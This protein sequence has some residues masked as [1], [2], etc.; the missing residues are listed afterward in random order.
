MPTLGIELSDAGF[1]TATCAGDEPRLVDIPDREGS[2]EWPGF[3]YHDGTGYTFG[4]AAEEHWFVQPRRV[5]HNFW[6]RLA[7]EPCALSVGG[8]KPPSTSELAYFFLREFHSRL[9]AAAIEH[10]QL[11]LALPGGY[12]KDPASA[13]EKV[14]LLLGMA[15][16]LQLPLAGMVDMACAAL[17][18]PR[19]S[20]FNPA[21][22]VV[23]VDVTLESTDLT[24]LTTDGRLERKDFFQ[25]PQAG[26]AHLLKHL[27][28]T[29]G[30]RFL[31]Q[32]TF[33]ILE[34]GRIEQTFFRQTKDFFLGSA[35]EFRFHINTATRGY[36]MIAK[37]ELLAAD[38]QAFV[39]ALVQNVQ[40][41]I[42]NSP[43]ASEPCTLALT[44]RAAHLPALEAK[45]RAAGYYRQLRLPYGAA[46]C[47]AACIGARR[48][49]VP[50]D[51]AEVRVESSVPLTETRRSSGAQWDAQLKKFRDAGPRLA[52]THAI[53]NGVGHPIGTKNRFTIGN[54]E[55]GAD[56][57]LP[58]HFNT[59][60]DCTVP[61]VNDGG[62]LWFV[63]VA[64]DRDTAAP[65][66]PAART[67]ID[68][69]DRLTVRC[70]EAAAE[71][72]FVHCRPSNGTHA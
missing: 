58:D 67:A 60:D 30:N 4:R 38:T 21:L 62:R 19:A 72:L 45:L 35:P 42:Q 47:G 52:P 23:V 37:R 53:F 68:A 20:G 10:E 9:Q 25:L 56:L 43:H 36:E 18:D 50:A 28:G 71:I 40:T 14:G 41:F 34:D 15:N 24:L 17:C 33:D 7:H 3:A 26:Y 55:L 46:A 48:W 44:D 8:A 51:L 29:M 49:T 27:T 6:A 64:P 70:G 61:L 66:A 57:P 12:L 54:A 31:R 2:A 59:A 32:T 63:D 69:G 1:L 5:L 13:E 11:V 16:D 65:D 39:T 22:P